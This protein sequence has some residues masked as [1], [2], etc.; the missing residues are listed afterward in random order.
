MTG[1]MPRPWALFA[2]NGATKH[3]GWDDFKGT[4]QTRE[5]A[6]AFAPRVFDWWQIVNMETQERVA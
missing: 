1:K 2:G 6:E 4:F 3:G 5:E